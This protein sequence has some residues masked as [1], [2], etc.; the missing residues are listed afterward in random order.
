MFV[1]WEIMKTNTFLSLAVVEQTK[2]FVDQYMLKGTSR[3]LRELSSKW[4]RER[5]TSVSLVVVEQTEAFVH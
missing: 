5:C 3:V 2:F 1:N 4:G